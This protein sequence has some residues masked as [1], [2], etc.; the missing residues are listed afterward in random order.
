MEPTRI[1]QAVCESAVEA[2]FDMLGP[3]LALQ[4]QCQTELKHRPEIEQS[5]IEVT[6]LQYDDSPIQTLVLRVHFDHR[7]RQL[8]VTNILM[9]QGMQHQRLGKRT[10]G[11]LYKVAEAHDYELLVVDMVASF[12]DRLVCRG[13]VVVDDHSV[14]ITAQMNFSGDVDKATS[15]T[16]PAVHDLFSLILG[17]PDKVKEAN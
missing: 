5:L 14:K 8:K 2:I 13:A 6:C 10:L 7:S 9:P 3:G 4:S 16:G 1:A 11:E 12:Y 17:K 15:K